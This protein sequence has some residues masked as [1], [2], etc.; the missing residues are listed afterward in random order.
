MVSPEP[1]LGLR[2]PHR[3]DTADDITTQGVAPECFSGP[4]LGSTSSASDSPP[5]KAL[6]VGAWLWPA[7]Q[8]G[9]RSPSGWKCR[10]S[11][12]RLRSSPGRS[13]VGKSTQTSYETAPALYMSQ[14]PSPASASELFL[15][16]RRR[17][18]R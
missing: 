18:Q 1:G 13:A 3:G 8:R 4:A 10:S 7:P 17:L 14:N 6:G 2:L 9:Q 16:L 11:Q 15:R 12:A 5:N